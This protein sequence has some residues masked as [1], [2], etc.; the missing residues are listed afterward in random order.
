MSPRLA[1]AETRSCVVISKE[2]GARVVFSVYESEREAD[3]IRSRLQQ[4]GIYA[5]IE[6]V[7]DGSAAPGMT[8][9]QQRRRASR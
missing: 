9:R 1:H 3:A 2:S 6:R 8:I 7:R 4:L 5:A